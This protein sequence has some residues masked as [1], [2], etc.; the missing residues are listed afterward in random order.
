M[1]FL[2][3]IFPTGY[4]AAEQAGIKGGEIVAIWGT[5]PVGLF[6]I[7]S[8]KVLGADRIIAI[9]TV[10]E[11]IA[12]ARKAG[13]TD[14]ID[15][16]KE[17]VF[18]RIKE[19]SK[20]EGAD[21]VIDCVG[22]ETSPGPRTGRPGHRGEGEGHAGRAHLCARPGH[23]GG[24]AVRSGFGAGRLRGPVTVDMGSIVQKGLRLCSGQTH[25]KRYLEPLTKLIQEKKVDSTFMIT[26]R[27]TDLD[28][29][30]DLYQ[31]F[32]AKKDGCVKVVFHPA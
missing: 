31:T 16:A 28:D 9:E 13:A 4:Q 32:K 24:A 10:P 29:G 8:S 21:V 19:I 11:R 7:Q 23:Q 26:H 1:L 25:V 6:A 12:M 2:T 30:P 17:D 5:G 18:E 15:F 27:S 14:I 20:G 22:M 3:D